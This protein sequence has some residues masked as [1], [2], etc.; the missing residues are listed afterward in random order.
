MRFW[1]FHPLVFY[2]LALLAAGLLIAVSLAPQAWPRDPAPVAAQRSDGALVLSGPAFDSP[3]HGPEQHVFVPRD[4]WGRPQALRIAVL[5]NRGEPAPT[6]QGAR[7]L[8]DAATAAQLEGRPVVAEV[9]YN[10]LPINAATGL[11]VSLQGAGG[12]QWVTQPAQPQPGVLR[13]ELPAQSGVSALGLRAISSG[14]DQA[15]GLEITRIVLR[16]HA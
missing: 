10:P 12:A 1:L 3:A 9:S 5:P 8:L 4:L 2:P 6:E 15:Y 7:I 14:T 11:A 16:P 13:F